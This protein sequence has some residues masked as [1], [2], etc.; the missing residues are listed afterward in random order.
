MVSLLHRATI[1]KDAATGCGIMRQ[2][3]SSWAYLRAERMLHL[4]I[5]SRDSRLNH[6]SRAQECTSVGRARHC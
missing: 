4:P 5:H 2:Y 3:G 6:A 1:N